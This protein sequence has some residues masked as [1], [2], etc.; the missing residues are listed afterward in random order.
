VV[1]QF[2]ESYDNRTGGPADG[3]GFD[4]D[5]GTSNSIL[6]YNYSHANDG[7]GFMLAHGRTDRLHAGNIVRYN[8]SQ[9]DGRKN[10]YGG[11]H[12]WTDHQR[13][14]PQQHDL[15]VGDDSRLASRHR[16]RQSRRRSERSRAR[17]FPQQHRADDGLGTRSQRQPLRARPQ[18]GCASRRQCVLVDRGRRSAW[19]GATSRTALSP[20]GG[21]RQGRS[22]SAPWIPA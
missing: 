7:A 3:G 10:K 5:S 21:R 13:G 6:Q 8:V 11:I 1:I 15:H 9:N 14:D 20:H 19:C 17:P 18:R 16:H 4:L 12:L 2:N 22:A